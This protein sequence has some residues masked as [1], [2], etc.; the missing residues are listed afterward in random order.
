MTS[1][2]RAAESRIAFLRIT[3][4]GSRRLYGPL[5]S[6]CWSRVGWF[7]DLTLIRYEPSARGRSPALLQVLLQPSLGL[8]ENPYA[9]ERIDDL[10]DWEFSTRRALEF[11][12]GAGGSPI[13]ARP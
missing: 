7:I 10:L 2:S 3:V 12:A 5:P 4:A 8:F 9:R 11:A 13:L 6:S 1:E